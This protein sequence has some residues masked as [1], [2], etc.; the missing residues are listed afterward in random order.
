MGERGEQLLQRK[1]KMPELLLGGGG[2]RSESTHPPVAPHPL[3]SKTINTFKNNMFTSQLS[4]FPPFK[5]RTQYSE[6]TTVLQL[7]VSK[8][9]RLYSQGAQLQPLFQKTNKTQNS[10][11][12]S[13]RSAPSLYLPYAT[14]IPRAPSLTRIPLIH[15]MASLLFFNAK[16][17]TRTPIPKIV[18][19]FDIRWRFTRE[20]VQTRE[21]R[22]SPDEFQ[23][24]W[25]TLFSS[26]LP[27]TPRNRQ[28]HHEIHRIASSTTQHR[29]NFCHKE[30]QLQVPI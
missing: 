12:Y 28:H 9:S 30:H 1:E 13:S 16:T 15:L 10:Q 24:D 17:S 11:I 14:C 25:Q 18:F 7:K 27:Q 5:I 26:Y 6:Y 29:P 4:T 8:P 19:S 2:G 22:L 23:V 3:R 20:L 21:R